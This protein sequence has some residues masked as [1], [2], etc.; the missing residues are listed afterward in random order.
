MKKILSF[1]LVL[2]MLL[3]VAYIQVSATEG[4]T[5]VAIDS[6]AT[7]VSVGGE[8]Y[9]VIRTKDDL[10]TAAEE[11]GRYIL[12]NDLSFSDAEIG[13]III[14]GNG[15]ILDG[16]GYGLTDF[17]LTH[18][19]AGKDGIFAPIE[20]G[21]FTVKNLHFG[22]ENDPVDVDNNL[23]Y[24]S[25]DTTTTV[26][27]WENVQV[28]MNQTRNGANAGAFVS[29]PKGTHSFKNVD[30]YMYKTAVSGKDNKTG[31]FFGT[32]N[33]PTTLTFENCNVYGAIENFGTA[34]GFIG[35]VGTKS[36]ISFKNCKN[37]AS[38]T[39]HD[40]QGAGGFIGDVR[41]GA[42]GSVITFENCVNNGVISMSGKQDNNG[43][44]INGVGGFVGNID[45]GESLTFTNCT[46]NGKL[47]AKGVDK[48]YIG[49][50]IG[51]AGTGSDATSIA[52]TGCV[53]TADIIAAPGADVVISAG[54]LIG[55]SSNAATVVLVDCTNIGT[56]TAA[57]AAAGRAKLGNLAGS[58]AAWS[59]TGCNAFG[60]LVGA[61]AAK[62]VLFGT[63]GEVTT[64]SGNKYIEGSA[65]GENTVGADTAVTATQAIEFIT[66]T[67]TDVTP[68][69]I[70][71][72]GAPVSAAPALKATQKGIATTTDVRLI[73]T[74]QT[75]TYDKVG[76]KYKI[77]DGQEQ[78]V[79]ADTLMAYVCGTSGSDA[80][81]VTAEQLGGVYVYVYTINGV[82]SDDTIVVTPI[83]EIGE[84]VYTGTA[85]TLEY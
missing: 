81:A 71:E 6:G 32:T 60:T 39:A 52:L 34:G 30:V 3:S 10:P 80:V 2:T 20:N 44:A 11:N 78:T 13:K 59:A 75:C 17:K 61:N 28:Y 37:F 12:A 85:V 48:S 25:N 47:Y 62:G 33:Q 66:T 73:A 40:S 56:V 23:V 84:T 8:T 38:V 67:F 72:S 50:F 16:N 70:G 27:N 1:M 5:P 22:E 63:S 9:K 24:R 51:T 4:F 68:P 69:I 41:Q 64:A 55:D 53:N 21:G 76:F 31:G 35:Y 49:G 65:N 14:L 42:S 36:V 77:N 26:T 54:G 7:T 74:V 58:V 45:K 43:N 57:A 15:S 19:G 82:N 29:S 18:G 79:Y 83:S 46:N